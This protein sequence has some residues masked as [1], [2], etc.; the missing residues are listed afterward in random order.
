VGPGERA[1]EGLIRFRLGQAE[2][3]RRAR[4]ASLVRAVTS[5]API[6]M[7]VVLVRRL[8][9]APGPAF[10]AVAGALVAL[11]ATRALAGYGGM[12]RKLRALVVTVSEED[13][14]VETTGDAY[15]IPRG[16]VARVV[17]I[18]GSLGGLR[19]ESLP[20]PRSGVVLEAH[21]PRG[22]EGY[23]DVRR[24]LESWGPV[25]RRGRRG[26]AVRVAIGALVVGAIF[27]VPFLLED[28]VARSRVVA[29]VLVAGMWI[30]MR[31]AMRRQ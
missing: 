14:R 29:A 2:A 22:G 13:I 5:L 8:A 24:R 11:V 25:E 15:S 20:D 16:R 3:T 28:F 23:A 4:A 9:W 10:W 27:F 18:A 1:V 6:V 21:V 19:V 31:V 12:R 7:A 30:A 26:P 17:E